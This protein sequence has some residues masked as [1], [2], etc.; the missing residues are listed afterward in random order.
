MKISTVVFEMSRKNHNATEIFSYSSNTKIF[1]RF[2][3]IW[4]CIK[5]SC[6]STQVPNKQTAPTPIAAIYLMAAKILLKRE[7]TSVYTAPLPV[8][9]GGLSDVRVLNSCSRAQIHKHRRDLDWSWLA[10]RCFWCKQHRVL[11]TCSYHTWMPILCLKEHGII[12]S[13]VCFSD[14][15]NNAHNHTYRVL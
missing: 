4:R 2:V 10:G 11:N 12:M 1:H 9:W 15:K 5:H 6:E 7:R 13:C 8:I 3:S 14:L